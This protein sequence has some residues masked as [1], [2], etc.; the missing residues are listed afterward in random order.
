[1]DYIGR[2]RVMHPHQPFL[3]RQRTPDLKMII[4]LICLSFKNDMI[5]TYQVIIIIQTVAQQ[6]NM[7]DD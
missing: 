7:S 1:M 6:N 3:N 5:H 4:G 2:F